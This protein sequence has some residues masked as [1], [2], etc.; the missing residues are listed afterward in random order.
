M[1]FNVE[2]KDLFLSYKDFVALKYLSFRLEDKKI[3]GL[4]GRNGAGK[5]SLLSLL[6]SL[7]EPTKG[8]IT[9]AGVPPIENPEIMQNVA[10]IHQA[11]Y[12][13]ET[14]TAKKLL[15]LVAQYRPNYDATY[16]EYLV[17]RFNLP[18]DRAVNKLSQEMQAVL[19][20]IIGLASRAPLTI[21]D[22][23][24]LGMDA[25]AR[26]I[27]YQEIL[28]DQAKFPR[29]FIISTHLVPEMDNLFDEVLILHQGRLI[30]K[31]ESKALISRG[32]TI[33]GPVTE[34]DEFVQDRNVIGEKHLGKTKVV[35]VFADNNTENNEELKKEA[36]R[37]GFEASQIS[38]Q[39]LFIQLT[40]EREE[41]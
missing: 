5:T 14:S 16:A 40:D 8:S 21:F 11:D 31:E 22:E 37:K 41:N 10:F 30:L 33:T 15:E 7:R 4:I 35:M 19:D 36:Q 13:D 26:M 2:V 25:S 28:D 38:L 9:I 23:V 24:Y 29:L 27:F 1:N 20:V 3:Y 12:R 39:D 32:L 18:V 17:Q 34:V 6:A